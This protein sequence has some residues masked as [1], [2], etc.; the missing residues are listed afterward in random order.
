VGEPERAERGVD[1]ALPAHRG[2]PKRK[3]SCDSWRVDPPHWNYL[4]GGPGRLPC[5]GSHRSGRAQLTHPARRV[6]RSL[7]AVAAAAEAGTA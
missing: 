5:R 2:L 6:T 7:S 1:G 3:T 4:S